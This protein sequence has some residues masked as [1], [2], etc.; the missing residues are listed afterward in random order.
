L[1][2][3][4]HDADR[5]VLCFAGDG[6]FQMNCAELGTGMQAGLYPIVLIVNNGSYGT[7]RMHQE[8]N[9]PHRVSGTDLQ[10]PDFAGLARSYGFYGETVETT[11]QFAAAFER[12]MQSKT[13]AVLNLIVATEAIT[14][15]LSIDDLRNAGA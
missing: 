5:F 14:P 8:R 6:D 4:A 13:G 15:R 10:N 11:D 3:K 2:A 7:I 1:A 12:A 9:Y